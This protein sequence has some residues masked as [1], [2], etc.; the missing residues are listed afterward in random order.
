MNED[1]FGMLEVDILIPNDNPDTDLS[2]REYYDEFAPLFVTAEL[3]F[4]CSGTYMTDYTIKHNLSQTPRTLLVGGLRVQ[5][6]LLFSPLVKWY[7]EEGLVITRVHEVIEYSKQKCF[8]KFVD[9]V[10][11]ARREGDRDL[12]KLIIGILWG[13]SGGAMMLGKLPVP[14]RPT[15]WM[16]VGQGPT[17]LAVGAGGGC[18]DIFTLLYLFSPLS[19]SL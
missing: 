8:S 3:P 19:P 1:F 11:E 12:T 10:S 7:I 6:L 5:K 2:P 16:I 14:G 18:L 9:F 4:S 13:W 17:A 15:I